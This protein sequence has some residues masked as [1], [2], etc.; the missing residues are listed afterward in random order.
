M[1][2]IRWLKYILIVL[3]NINIITLI[4]LISFNKDKNTE[5]LPS[6]TAY[7]YTM[8]NNRYLKI[9][10]SSDFLK[11]NTGGILKDSILNDINSYVTIF[12]PEVFKNIDNVEKYFEKNKANIYEYSGIK[13]Y[14]EFENLCDSMNKSLVEFNLY[15]N[16]N[17]VDV[18]VNES[19]VVVN[20]KINYDNNLYID[21]DV[22][23][24]N[25]KLEGFY[26]KN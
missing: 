11:M 4:Y 24:N 23:Y 6:P 19:K 1:E 25:E 17:F 7:E 2:K 12:L 9:E 3:I 13:Q 10:N 22:V 21:M 20:I 5:I 15:N 16:I 18:T 26:F 14:S 8:Q